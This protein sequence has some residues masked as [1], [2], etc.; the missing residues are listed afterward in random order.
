LK[1]LH[2]TTSAKP[3]LGVWV[4]STNRLPAVA[5]QGGGMVTPAVTI[6]AAKE[7]KP[8]NPSVKEVLNTAGS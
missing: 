2:G 5:G 1:K 7:I 6:R 4:S 8:L 3:T